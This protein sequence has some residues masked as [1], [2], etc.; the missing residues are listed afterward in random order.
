[1]ELSFSYISH[2]QTACETYSE[3]F[4]G[5]FSVPQNIIMDLNNVMGMYMGVIT[6]LIGVR[7]FHAC[8]A[9]IVLMRVTILEDVVI[10]PPLIP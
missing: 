9:D 6:S 4:N 7:V 10:I 3:I 2:I 8:P 1:M 5:I